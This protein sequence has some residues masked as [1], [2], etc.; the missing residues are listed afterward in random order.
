MYAPVS[1]V[2]AAL[3]LELYEQL[4]LVIFAINGSDSET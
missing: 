3:H 1:S 2:P 4:A